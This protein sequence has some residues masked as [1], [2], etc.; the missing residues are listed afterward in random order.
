MDLVTFWLTV[1]VSVVTL[2]DAGQRLW[3]WSRRK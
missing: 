2:A 1:V 3:R